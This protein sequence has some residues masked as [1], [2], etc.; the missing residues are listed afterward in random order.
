MLKFCIAKLKSTVGSAVFVGMMCGSFA[1]W[2]DVIADRK[3][4]FKVH[5][6]FPSD[7]FL[8]QDLFRVCHPVF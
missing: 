1:A 6:Y 8:A 4:N 7:L 5:V 3:A 2:A